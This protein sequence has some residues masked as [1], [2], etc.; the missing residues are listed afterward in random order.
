MKFLKNWL[1][2]EKN[3]L[4]DRFRYSKTARLVRFARF[5][6]TIMQFKK[7]TKS[8]GIRTPHLPFTEPT[9]CEDVIRILENSILPNPATSIR[10]RKRH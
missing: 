4:E 7:H 10:E 2:L 9:I 8:I 5:F 6:E 1:M 3:Y